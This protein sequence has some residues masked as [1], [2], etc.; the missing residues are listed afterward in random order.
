MAVI[1]L[2][3]TAGGTALYL[4][5]HLAAAGILALAALAGLAELWRLEAP[6]RDARGRNPHARRGRP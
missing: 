4:G 5:A 2:L 6:R 1:A 3:L